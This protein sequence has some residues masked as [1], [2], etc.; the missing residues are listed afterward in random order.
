MLRFRLAHGAHIFL[1][2]VLAALVVLHVTAALV[3]AFVWRD[4]TLGRMWRRA[5]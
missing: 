4:R 1:A 2:G 3:H 5:G